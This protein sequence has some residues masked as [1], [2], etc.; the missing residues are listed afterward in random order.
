MSS[1]IVLNTEQVLSIASQLEADNAALQDLLNQSKSTIM[2]LSSV[3]T[4]SAAEQART[5]YESFA[6]KYFETYYDLLEQYV[7][8]LRAN[9]AEQYSQAESSNTRLADAFE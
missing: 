5:S 3:W 4:G 1:R 6:S 7:R 9:V 2:G 8:F